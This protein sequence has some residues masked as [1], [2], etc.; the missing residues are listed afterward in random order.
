MTNWYY[1][2]GHRETQSLERLLRT[3]RGDPSAGLSGQASG[4]SA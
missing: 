4:L 2:N 3:D 1:Y